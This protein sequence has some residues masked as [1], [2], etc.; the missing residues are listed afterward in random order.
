V[1][2]TGPRG[3]GTWSTLIPVSG[4][5]CSL[6]PSSSRVEAFQKTPVPTAAA[7]NRWAAVSSSV[8]MVAASPEVSVFAI[9]TASSRSATTATVTVASRP[10]SSA[11]S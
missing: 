1:K 7:M 8:T 2:V 3:P 10:L 9:V 6:K 5:P 4:T 11:H